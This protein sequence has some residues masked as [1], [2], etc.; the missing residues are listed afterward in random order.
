MKAR[1][2]VEA[3]NAKRSESREVKASRVHLRPPRPED[4]GEFLALRKSSRKFLEPWE[5]DTP[6]EIDMFAA[7]GVARFLARANTPRR[8]RLFVCRN[9]DGAILG[10]VTLSQITR[11]ALQTATIGYWIGAKHARQGF[12][13]EALELAFDHAFRKLS[14]NR[15][16]AAILPE[17]SASKAIA[18]QRGFHFEGLSR[19]YAKLG[20]KWR[21]HERWAITKSD[22]KKRRGL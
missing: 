10:A 16:E 9:S 18:E 1:S 11:G 14:L 6:P 5:P 7:S 13:S 8:E 21:D 19:G 4:G 3:A 17:N 12:M 15:L 22:W 20:G 2:K